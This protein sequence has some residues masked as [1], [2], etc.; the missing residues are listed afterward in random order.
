M[1]NEKKV[2]LITGANKGLG[3]EMAKQLGQKGT[4]VVVIA[5]DEQKGQ[6]AVELRC[7]R[8]RGFCFRSEEQGRKNCEYVEHLGS[9][10]L[11]AKPDSPIYDFKSFVYDAS[12]AALNSFTIHLA[13]EL[14]DTNIKI[15]SAHPGWVKTDMGTNA[16]PL[17]ILEGAK[18]GVVDDNRS[19]RARH[20]RSSY[21]GSGTFGTG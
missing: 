4:T 19:T 21:L 18:T 9:Q 15:N 6:A 5:R 8:R 13:H 3:F 20:A 7:Y 14:K 11:N 17:Q 12:K 16:A 10:T 1:A 2:A